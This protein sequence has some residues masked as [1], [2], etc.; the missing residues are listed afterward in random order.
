MQE[1]DL[2][3]LL[4]VAKGA[5]EIALRHFGA[6]PKIWEK[7]DNAGP[8]TEADLA[9]NAY[10]ETELRN[11]R[12]DYGWLSEETEDGDGR[13][14][15]SRQFIID[16][17][18]GTRAFIEGSENW[19]HSLAVADSGKPVAAVVAMP[20]KAKTF[21]AAKGQ[22]AWLNGDQLNVGRIER[23]EDATVLTAKPNL[24]AEHWR[25]GRVPPF[26]TTFRSSL[27]YRMCLV[28]SGRFD[29]MLSLRPTWEWDIA[30]GTLIVEEAGGVV[31][32]QEGAPLTFN[33]PHPTTP[34]VLA[35]GPVIAK[36]ASQL[37]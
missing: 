30:A 6:D 3:L 5:G 11:A 21:S 31:I 4:R 36:L 18:D 9:V 27:A 20:K 19:A 17:I 29:A 22:G 37:A 14:R 32:D 24:N 8:V 23:I 10:L 35:G 33:N 26:K 15:T 2:D 28:A 7:D 12:P 1:S 16:P 13:L 25:D 34:G